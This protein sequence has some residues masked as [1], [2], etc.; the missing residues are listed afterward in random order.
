[1]KFDG[2]KTLMFQIKALGIP[3]PITE[4]RF[5]PERMWRADFAWPNHKLLVEYEGGI[6]ARS[7]GKGQ[8]YGWHQSTQ[9]MLT[10]M[11]KYNRAALLGYRVLRY[12]PREVRSGKA[13]AE[14][15]QALKGGIQI[16]MQK[17]MLDA[18][19]SPDPA[20]EKG[21]PG[22]LWQRYLLVSHRPEAGTEAGGRSRFCRRARSGF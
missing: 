12:S 14:I 20:G 5:F 7:M 9:R 8:E 16:P 6:F 2:K 22:R 15:E 19:L 10:D 13:V 4:Y 18:A 3:A 17:D 1:M 11:E 21:A